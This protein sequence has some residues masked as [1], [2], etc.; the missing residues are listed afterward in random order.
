M[1]AIRRNTDLVEKFNEILEFCYNY[2]EP[3]FLTNNGQ[4]QLAVMSIDTY[5]ELAGRLE[6]YQLLDEGLEQELQ[7]KTRTKK[8]VMDSIKSKMGF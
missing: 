4:G 6:L 7:G 2:R 3:V 1:P 8:E 5:E